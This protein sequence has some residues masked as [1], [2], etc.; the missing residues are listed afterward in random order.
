VYRSCIHEW[1]AKGREERKDLYRRAKPPLRDAA[2]IPSPPLRAQDPEIKIQRAQSPGMHISRRPVLSEF[3]A[4]NRGGIVGF[5]PVG[6]CVRARA[7]QCVRTHASSSVLLCKKAWDGHKHR[8][9]PGQAGN[10]PG[11]G[12]VWY[13]PEA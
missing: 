6:L 11:P 2:H 12:L 8:A 4:P 7:K 1:R 13:V 3:Q 10:Q 5:S 9:Q